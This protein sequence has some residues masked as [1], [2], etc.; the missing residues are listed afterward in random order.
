MAD[1]AGI[2]I[3][4]AAVGFGGKLMRTVSFFGWILPDSLF[5]AAGGV[6]PAGV[7]G[8]TAPAPDGI[9]GLLSAICVSNKLRFQPHSVNS[10]APAILK[11]SAKDLLRKSKK[12][13]KGG[14]GGKMHQTAFKA[15][16]LNSARAD[17]RPANHADHRGTRRHRL[18]GDGPRRRVLRAGAPHSR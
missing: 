14:T 7:L 5:G 12:E 18:H 8:G 4:G 6:A 1:G 17:R 3:V 16:R 2:L 10:I 11:E 13:Q 15:V 9:F